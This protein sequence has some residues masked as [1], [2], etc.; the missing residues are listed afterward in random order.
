[1]PDNEG[2]FFSK[3]FKKE[4][5]KKADQIDLHSLPAFIKLKSKFEPIQD[6]LQEGLFPDSLTIGD[7]VDIIHL[8]RSAANYKVIGAF[9]SIVDIAKTLAPFEDKNRQIIESELRN[10]ESTLSTP[11]SL[12]RQN[13]LYNL[14]PDL[15]TLVA[16]TNNDLSHMPGGLMVIEKSGSSKKEPRF[17]L[18]LNNRHNT[19]N[20][21]P[22]KALLEETGLPVKA[23]DSYHP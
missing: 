7:F 17:I 12:D 21:K 15:S 14:R 16:G 20:G 2:S 6:T 11:E 1:M 8:Y 3:F 18:W 9:G 10:L 23:P 19:D 13:P 4:I 5:N 22:V